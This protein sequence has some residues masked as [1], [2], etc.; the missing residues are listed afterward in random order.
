MEEEEAMHIG[1]RVAD[2][3]GASTL[4]VGPGIMI[5][6]TREMNKRSPDT[7]K[8]KTSSMA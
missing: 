5:N 8:S 2:F 3:C 6:A 4:S 1:L 7:F